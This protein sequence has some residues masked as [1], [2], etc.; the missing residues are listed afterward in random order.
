MRIVTFNCGLVEPLIPYAAERRDLIAEVLPGLDADLIALQ[1]VWTASDLAVIG[2]A[3][4]G[5]HTM[6]A[7][8][9]LPE[10]PGDWVQE[11]R[12]GTV[13]LSR[14]PLAR[15]SVV[16]LDSHFVR[17]AVVRAEVASEVG[18]LLVLATHLA[19][20]IPPVPHP[21][22]G[23]W[24]AEHA[25]QVERLIEDAETWPGPA[26]LAGD[27]NCGPALPGIDGEFE[28]GYR[29]LREAFPGSVYEEQGAPECTFC[30]DNPLQPFE[31]ST[32]LDHVLTRGIDLPGRARRIFDEPV[33]IDGAPAR[34]SDHYGLEVDYPEL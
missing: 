3:L 26:M 7:A 21:D 10:V 23:G 32:L 20:D 29:R 5:S 1:E 11:A 8:D 27:L 14:V 33:E 24:E 28:A 18:P 13:L 17:R 22:P 9:P 19:A 31:Q 4:A 15:A 16:P 25:S 34:L 2:E 30:G 12:C 6:V